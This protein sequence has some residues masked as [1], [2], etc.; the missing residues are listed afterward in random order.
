MTF[1]EKLKAFEISPQD[2]AQMAE[3]A[4]DPRK[5]IMGCD[6]HGYVASDLPPTAPCAECWKTWMIFD[7]AHTQP[8]K[9]YERLQYLEQVIRKLVEQPDAFMPFAKHQVKIEK[10]E[11]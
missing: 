4:A 8:S 9:R 7:I 6:I 11:D 1:K 5:A 10:G 2:Q 3:E